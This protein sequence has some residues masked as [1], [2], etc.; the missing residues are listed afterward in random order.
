MPA[1]REPIVMNGI[2]RPIVGSSQTADL[3]W[4]VLRAGENLGFA[5][6]ELAREAGLSDLR[7]WF[8]LSLASDG[9]ERTQLEICAELGIDKTTMV[10]LLDRLEKDG[11]IVRRSS[12]T[13][14]RIRIPEA[15]EAGRAIQQ[16]VDAAR[17][18]A[19]RDRL[20]AISPTKQRIFREVI[21]ELAGGVTAD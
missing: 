2:R 10:S 11:L 13:D 19:I 4:M 18:A 16:Q 7:A 14:R 1:K 5:F 21:W 6:D 8:I 3:T 17:D 15:T 12:P 9:T 20:S